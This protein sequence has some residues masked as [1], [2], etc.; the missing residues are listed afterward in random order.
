M[1]YSS[2]RP[3]SCL[4]CTTDFSNFSLPVCLLQQWAFSAPDKNIL[5]WFG[6]AAP[7]SRLQ[8]GLQ[9]VL[10]SFT[11]LSFIL[12]HLVN[13][14]SSKCNFAGAY[15]MWHVRWGFE[16]SDALMGWMFLFALRS[17][18]PQWSA[19]CWRWP[20]SDSRCTTCSLPTWLV[21]MQEQ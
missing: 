13:W 1:T 10:T 16:L 9:A 5:S 7:L 8:T 20:G 12:K 2:H 6:L 11:Q 4:R 18:L 21:S 17:T 3:E 14:H 19:A 15:K